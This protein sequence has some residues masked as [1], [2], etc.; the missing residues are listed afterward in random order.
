MARQDKAITSDAEIRELLAG[1]RL[2][3]IAR[4]N[5][6]FILKAGGEVWL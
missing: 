5:D 6:V 2:A 3:S 4:E 1:G